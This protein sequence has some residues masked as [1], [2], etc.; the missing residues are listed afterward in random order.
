[1]AGEDYASHT[2]V[3][4]EESEG[5]FKLLCHER[6]GPEED[7]SAC[8]ERTVTVLKDPSWCGAYVVFLG[9]I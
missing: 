6:R 2:V 1:M 8:I 3:G 5:F 9:S 4:A 7:I